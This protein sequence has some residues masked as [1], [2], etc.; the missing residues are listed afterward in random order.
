MYRASTSSRCSRITTPRF[1]LRLGVSCP[2]SSVHAAG[3]DREPA[4]RLGLGDGLV[5]LLHRALD[6][7][8]QVGVVDQGGDVA[9]LAVLLGP[10]REGLGV[11]GDQRADE[12]LAV[13]DDD[14]LV[15]ERVCPEAV[16]EHGGRHVLATGGDQDLLLAP[17]D[18]DEALVVDLADVAGVEPALRVLGLGRRV[19]VVPVAREDLATTEEQLAVVGHPHAGALA[20][21]VR[22]CRSSGRR[23]GWRSARRWSR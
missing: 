14:A 23:A 13:P 19:V 4:D 6:L 21:A 22:P 3:Q 8:P 1:S 12:R 7:G 10:G 16:L 5:G 9:G 20:A 18:P 17:G 11:D 15:D 2:P